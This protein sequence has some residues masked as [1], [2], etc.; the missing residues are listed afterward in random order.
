MWLQTH[1]KNKW[2]WAGHVARM[3]EERLA[4]RALRWRDSEWWQHE[5]ELPVRFQTRRPHR[6]RWFR[7]EDELRRFAQQ[8]NQKP[9]QDLAQERETWLKL[10]DDFI[11]K[12]GG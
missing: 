1:L 6:T 8:R 4:G 10:T 2:G 3:D 12:N 5:L 11:K 9:W 7:W